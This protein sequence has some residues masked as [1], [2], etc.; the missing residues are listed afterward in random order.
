MALVSIPSPISTRR[1]LLAVVALFSMAL[2]EEPKGYGELKELQ[3]AAWKQKTP[4]AF[5]AL[6]EA[7]GADAQM[8]ERTI[9]SE[10][11]NFATFPEQT[12]KWLEFLSIDEMKKRLD[13]GTARTPKGQDLSPA[14]R[15]TIEYATTGRKKGGEV[16]K[17]NIPVIGVIL[18]ENV[19]KSGP[20]PGF[21]QIVHRVKPVG[22]TADGKLRLVLP[23]AG[24]G[25]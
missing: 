13:N 11:D 7:A 15:N 14:F 19:L 23:A 20:N 9:K 16:V 8:F 25:E 18:M 2:A 4:D 1:C 3:A 6:Y 17:P 12:E 21:G 24:T 22:I 5:R 10:I